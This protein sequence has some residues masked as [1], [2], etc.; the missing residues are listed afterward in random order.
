MCLVFTQ[1]S[2]AYHTYTSRDSFFFHHSLGLQGTRSSVSVPL[3][4]HQ[5][6]AYRTLLCLVSSHQYHA[7]H[8]I[9]T[10]LARAIP[11]SSHFFFVGNPE[12]RLALNED[13]V[14]GKSNAGAGFGSVVLDVSVEAARLDACCCCTREWMGPGRTRGGEG[15]TEGR[16]MGGPWH[17]GSSPGCG[18]MYNS[19]YIYILCLVC[20]CTVSHAVRGRTYVRDENSNSKSSVKSG[21]SEVP[22]AKALSCH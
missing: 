9:H 12:L 3:P 17:R 8:T 10:C 13:L 7:Y 4:S 22:Q 21:K 5:Y 11:F 1:I 6:H 2:N 14:V 19:I 16:R 20:M 15:G 18:Y